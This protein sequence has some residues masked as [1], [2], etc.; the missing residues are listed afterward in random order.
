[1]EQLTPA[2]IFPSELYA[3]PKA[4][5]P[6]GEAY[7]N[8]PFYVTLCVSFAQASWE[9]KILTTSSLSLVANKSIFKVVSSYF[10][11]YSDI[12]T[13]CRFL[14]MSSA[15]TFFSPVIRAARITI[16]RG[17]ALLKYIYLPNQA[18][19]FKRLRPYLLVE[20]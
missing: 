3:I 8:I 15:N 17:F 16:N 7:S 20:I 14:T 12:Q 4:K 18:I 6:A 1:M 5:I 19:G 2:P 13:P 11:L 9:S 10:I